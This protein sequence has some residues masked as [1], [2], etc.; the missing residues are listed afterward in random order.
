MTNKEAL[1]IQ[2][3]KV[4]LTIPIPNDQVLISKVELQELQSQSL[5]GVYWTMK[6]IEQRTGRKSE[7][8]KDKILYPSKFRELLDSDN[9]GFV[10]YPKNQGQTWI[11]QANQMA[12]FLEKNFHKI[13]GGV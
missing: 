2:Q 7:W 13:F 6:D 8:I 12:I 5:S 4:N 3:L 1:N 11:F 10:F 9:G